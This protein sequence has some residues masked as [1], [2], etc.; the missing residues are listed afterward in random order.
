MTELTETVEIIIEPPVKETEDN[1]I[2][3][4]EESEL[5]IDKPA[6]TIIENC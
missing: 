4:G 2:L 6:F 5:V 1:G 3:L